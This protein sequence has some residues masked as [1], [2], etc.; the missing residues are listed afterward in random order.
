MCFTM[1]GADTHRKY[2]LALATGYDSFQVN[3][4]Y[5][6]TF[7]VRSVYDCGSHVLSN[8]VSVNS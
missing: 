7:I 5:I 1:D 8:F 2:L 3:W 6:N 4:V